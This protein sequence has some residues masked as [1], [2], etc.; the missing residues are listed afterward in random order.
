MTSARGWGRL[1]VRRSKMTLGAETGALARSSPKSVS[2]EM[3]I[4]FCLT[5]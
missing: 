2:A 1:S 4:W 5:R 3:R